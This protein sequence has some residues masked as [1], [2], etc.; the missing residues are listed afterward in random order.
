MR[1]VSFGG[2]RER[3]EDFCADTVDG[4]HTPNSERPAGMERAGEHPHVHL[5]CEVA[6]SAI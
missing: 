1:V 3:S 4:Y 2:V 6:V 5:P